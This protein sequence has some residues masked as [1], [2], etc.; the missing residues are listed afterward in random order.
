MTKD[1]VQLINKRVVELQAE[2]DA[3]EAAKKII[4]SMR[5]GRRTKKRGKKK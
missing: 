2:V 4:I 1:E 3:L 5:K